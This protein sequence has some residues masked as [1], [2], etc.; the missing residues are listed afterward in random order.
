MG[1]GSSFKVAAH[2]HLAPVNHAG[3][4][5]VS[6]PSLLD[7]RAGWVDCTMPYVRV[8]WTI[9]R[10]IKASRVELETD[11]MLAERSSYLTIEA[12]KQYFE[13]LDEVGKMM[14]AIQNNN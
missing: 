4:L 1:T 10:P 13:R 8:D 2:L 6:P 7:E 12:A 14:R 9:A 11:L 3:S 5:L